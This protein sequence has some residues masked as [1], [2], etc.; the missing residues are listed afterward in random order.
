MS[1]KTE[2]TFITDSTKTDDIL[3]LIRN[4]LLIHFTD[5][6]KIDRLFL[7]VCFVV[8][9]SLIIDLTLYDP[10]NQNFKK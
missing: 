3:K 4:Q 10:H 7:N 9:N 2:K 8:I 5:F 6:I 1:R